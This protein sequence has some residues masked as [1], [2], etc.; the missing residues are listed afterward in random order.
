MSVFQEV[1]PGTDQEKASVFL[2]LQ[3][4]PP[5]HSVLSIAWQD[6]CLFIALGAEND[7]KTGIYEVAKSLCDR[8]L[9]TVLTYKA[10]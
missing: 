1:G 2:G 10:I 8:A 5:R 3:Q 9:A 6:S 7:Q 4:E